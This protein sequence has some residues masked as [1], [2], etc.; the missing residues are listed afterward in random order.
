MEFV[1]IVFLVF[2]LIH[3]SFGSLNCTYVAAS[4][5]TERFCEWDGCQAYTTVPVGS[6]VHATCRANCSSDDE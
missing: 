2:S 3:K 6:I 1:T 5:A 4:A